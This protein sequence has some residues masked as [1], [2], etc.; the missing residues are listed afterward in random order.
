MKPFYSERFKRARRLCM[1]MYFLRGYA[2]YA[3]EEEVTAM[4]E[5]FE[6]ALR[7]GKDHLDFMD[8]MSENGL[9]YLVLTYGYPCFNSAWRTAQEEFK[10]INPHLRGYQTTNA[11]LRHVPLM[12]YGEVMQHQQMFLREIQERNT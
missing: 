12:S 2:M 6:G 1:R 9:L 5:K 10:K 8:I 3:T 4:C 11:R 7:K